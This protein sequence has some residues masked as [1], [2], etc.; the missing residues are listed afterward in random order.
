M[1]VCNL[2]Y[3]SFIALILMLF[4]IPVFGQTGEDAN[5]TLLPQANQ[6]LQPGPPP[7]K[8][9]PQEY[10]FDIDG[11]VEIKVAFPIWTTVALIFAVI[12]LLV[13][14]Y[15]FYKRKKTVSIPPILPWDRALNELA[16]AKTLRCPSTGLRYMERAS[17]ILR[18][19]IESRFAILTTRQTTREFLHSDA[20]QN[21]QQ[22]IDFRSDL[23]NCLEQADMAK[24]AH[25]IP[26]DQQLVGIED[27]VT[28]FVLR[29][30]PIAEKTAI[31]EETS[32][33]VEPSGSTGERRE[34]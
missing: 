32:S 13:L 34:T 5:L 11:P 28:N 3:L 14:G 16:E 10:L 21:H 4:C 7:S 20:L 31:S 9:G 17:L 18:N 27:A 25:L 2:L 8:A 29:T 12:V 15:L 30:K 24:F 26:H 23:R 33:A 19:Y 22:L 6:N 1:R